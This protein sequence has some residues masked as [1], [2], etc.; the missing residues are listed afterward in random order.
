M[1]FLVA[2]ILLALAVLYLLTTLA[3]SASGQLRH[4]IR[5]A[6]AL[7]ALLVLG[8]VLLAD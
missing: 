5:V 4:P 2:V 6:G 7:T 8:L 1:R 3:L